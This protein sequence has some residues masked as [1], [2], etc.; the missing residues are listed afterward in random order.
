MPKKPSLIDKRNWL[1]KYEGGKSE[2]AIASESKRDIRTIKNGIEE[3][4]RETDIR[5]ARA[6]LLKDALRKHQDS[7]EGELRN[8]LRDINLPNSD[9]APLSWYRDNGSI[10]TATESI[11]KTDERYQTFKVG[12]KSA[13][14][15]TTVLDLLRQHLKTDK[16]WK[17]L[18][19]WEKTLASHLAARK[20]FQR[21]VVA[22]LEE[23]TQYKVID[24]RDVAAPPFLFSNTTGHLLYKS[25]MDSPFG[26]GHSGKMED[27]MIT[28]TQRGVVTYCGSIL[29]EAPGYEEVTRSNILD[30]YRE[31]LAS[32]EL[33]NVTV[34]FQILKESVARV[35][36]AVEEILLLGFVPGQCNICR[37]L[38]L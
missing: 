18:A 15:T 28:D 21:K 34:T 6:E 26:S 4:R 12:R 36:Q 7:L 20:K 23:K 29:A 31:L 37:R 17:W 3:A 14:E 2:A 27:N 1:E 5:L 32:E 24:D 9:L 22:V 8:I 10:F 30:A 19:Q 33:T 13:T 25:A 16:L 35:R 11:E 38:G